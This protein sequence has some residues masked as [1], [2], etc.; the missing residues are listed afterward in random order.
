MIVTTQNNIYID[1]EGKAIPNCYGIEQKD[2]FYYVSS[3]ENDEG[4]IKKY[5]VDFNFIGRIATK[6]LNDIHEIRFVND[7]L[8][9]TNTSK[10]SIYS[11]NSQKSTKLYGHINSILYYNNL[12]YVLRA[13]GNIFI[14]DTD[15]SLIKEFKIPY[16]LKIPK[17]EAPNYSGWFHNLKIIDNWYY[18]CEKYGLIRFNETDYEVLVN[19]GDFMRGL[20]YDGNRWIVGQ[21]QS[22]PREERCDGDG[23]LLYYNN[24][25]NLIDTVILKDSGQIRDIYEGDTRQI[26]RRGQR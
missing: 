25:F 7:D 12:V 26:S 13:Y 24:D 14:L 5:D 19:T 2:N 4:V 3:Y 15:Y 17:G 6:P 10:E 1:G 11:I 23:T 21:S 18:T 22:T 9:I 8:L 16:N 20:V